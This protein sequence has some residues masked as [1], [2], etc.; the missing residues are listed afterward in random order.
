[1]PNKARII[2]ISPEAA[3]QTSLRFMLE[4]EG[5]SVRVFDSLQEALALDPD[6]DCAIVD[7]KVIGKSLTRLG[8]LAVLSR[9]V[10]LLVDQ[11]KDFSIPE[12]IR[13]V[14]KPLLGN[15]VIEAV[16]HA[17]SRR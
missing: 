16:S 5:C 2:V 12:M 1:M 8:E 6:Y 15:A 4:T 3:V 7:H 14:E 10:V 11:V 9:P 13:F 17:I